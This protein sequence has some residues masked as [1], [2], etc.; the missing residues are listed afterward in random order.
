MKTRVIVAL[1][2]LPLLLAVVLACPVW[3]TAL[4][5]GAMA[6]VAVH[7]LLSTTGIVRNGRIVA[8]SMLMALG[9]VAWS[10]FGFPSLWVRG[11]VLLYFLYLFCELL[12]A[13]VKL[14]FSGICVAAFSA[15]AVPYCLSALVRILAMDWGRYYIIAVFILAFTSDSGAYF[16][17]YLW[18]K[19]KLAPVISPKKTVEGFVGGIF[20]CVSFMMLYCVI[21]QFGFHLTVNYFYAAIFGVLGSL[22][23]V[24]GDLVFSVVKRQTGI[25][26]Y[27]KLMPGHGGILDRFDSTVVV[28][29]MTELLL[30]LLPLIVKGS[31]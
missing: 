24:L 14:A 21:L 17:G 10:Y 3:A 26:D 4:L 30:L 13:N 2:L 27:G 19:H 7:E 22:G 25:K 23:S 29:P 11:A 18:G 16:A 15:L 9:V 28:A 6:V 1:S 31:V 5:V 12:Y 8:V 20:S